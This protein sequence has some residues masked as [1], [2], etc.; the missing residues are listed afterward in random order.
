MAITIKRDG[1]I[2]HTDSKVSVEEKLAQ[3]EQ[4]IKDLQNQLKDLKQT[5]QKRNKNI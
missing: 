4:L 1:K 5:K 3:Q 2:I